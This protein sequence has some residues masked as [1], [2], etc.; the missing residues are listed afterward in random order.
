[1]GRSVEMGGSS[2]IG[3]SS[4]SWHEKAKATNA[5]LLY[6]RPGGESFGRVFGKKS[7]GTKKFWGERSGTHLGEFDFGAMLGYCL[8]YHGGA[9]YSWSGRGG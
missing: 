9:I 6:L 5:S 7:A 1:M 2:D 3:F 4:D 8:R